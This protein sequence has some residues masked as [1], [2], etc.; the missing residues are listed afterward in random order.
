M[1]FLNQASLQLNNFKEIYSKLQKIYQQNRYVMNI[2]RYFEEESNNIIIR[3]EFS[4]GQSK[5]FM[6]NLDKDFD[7]VE[8]AYF[9]YD[10]LRR[11][12]NYYIYKMVN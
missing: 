7:E 3:L 12:I 9:I 11:G 5:S 6:F 1:L 10:N 8:K 4:N 2:S